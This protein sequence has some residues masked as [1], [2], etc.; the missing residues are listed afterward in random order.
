MTTV[1]RW[2]KAGKAGKSAGPVDVQ[3][4]PS[5]PQSGG[6]AI[7]A[8]AYRYG[9][10]PIARSYAARLGVASSLTS[11]MVAGRFRPQ[12]KSNPPRRSDPTTS[13][14]T[15]DLGRLQTFAG[16]FQGPQTVRLGAQ[17][18]PSQ[19]P[20]FPNTNNDSSVDFSQMGLPDVWRVN[21]L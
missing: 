1:R 21:R 11:P 3:G 8:P 4:T 20:A 15:P 16:S 7:P 12:D 5:G 10:N 6:N 9:D 14:G 18:G 17:A 13:F 19:Q 2:G